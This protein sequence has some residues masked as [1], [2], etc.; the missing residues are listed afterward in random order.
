MKN[1]FTL[2]F[3]L[4]FYVMNAQENLKIEYE[5]RNEFDYQNA[6]DAKS[7]DMYKNSN[8]NRLYFELITS[9]DESTFNKID[10]VDNS[11]N[12]SGMSISFVSGPGGFFYKN[13]KDNN[14]LS[15]I[16]FNGKNLLISDSIPQYKWILKK[17]NSKI[18]GFDVKKAIL[19]ESE[20]TFVEAWYAPKLNY[21]NGP[22]NYGGLPGVI[23]KIILN[24][25]EGNQLNKQIYVATK[26]EVSDKFKINK[27]TKGKQISQADFEE[28]VEEENRKF[29]EMFLQK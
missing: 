3:C 9:N 15:E 2:F 17:E 5:F 25:K 28:M 18:L 11:Q 8:D 4:T 6:S 7:R 21:K 22:T 16:N 24:N 20:N 23:L 13:L 26:V 12:K 29:N 14:S 19:Q 10:R 1:I 27:P